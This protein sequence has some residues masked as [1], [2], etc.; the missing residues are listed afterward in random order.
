MGVA[1]QR[2][3]WARCRRLGL[4]QGCP[5]HGRSVLLLRVGLLP[6]AEMPRR[7]P[8]GLTPSWPGSRCVLASPDARSRRSRRPARAPPDPSASTTA[9]TR[10]ALS[11]PLSPFTLRRAPVGR[12]ELKAGGRA[13]AR[14][15]EAPPA[16]ATAAHGQPSVPWA[17]GRPP[18]GRRAPP[19]LAR[20]ARHTVCDLSGFVCVERGFYTFTAYELL[21][22]GPLYHMDTV[23]CS[24]P[25]PTG[26][27]RRLGHTYRSKRPPWAPW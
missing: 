14:P 15:P 23:L 24:W 2:R 25:D 17:A 26:S 16:A 11:A 18:I 27:G 21:Q 1:A 10:A 19:R 3:R 13:A 7:G 22:T 6:G 5:W 12:C 4:A 20:A 9:R 8:S